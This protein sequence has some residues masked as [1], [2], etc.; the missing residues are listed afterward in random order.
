MENGTIKDTKLFQDFHNY[1]IGK[2]ESMG[3]FSMIATGKRNTFACIEWKILNKKNIK[4]IILLNS[5]AHDYS[6][7]KTKIFI[8]KAERLAIYKKVSEIVEEK[9]ITVIQYFRDIHISIN[10]YKQ[11]V[12]G[13][14]IYKNESY[15]KL[16]KI[17]FE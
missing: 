17:L 15:Q 3:N 6:Y 13:L 16:T 14:N 12:S 5:Q 2:Y 9:G 8:Y 4:Y 10:T 7:D 1:V 11:I